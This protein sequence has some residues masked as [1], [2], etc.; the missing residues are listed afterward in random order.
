MRQTITSML[1][2]SYNTKNKESISQVKYTPIKLK[3]IQYYP[4]RD[5]NSS[6]FYTTNTG[7]SFQFRQVFGGTSVLTPFW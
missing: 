2:F 4:V 7:V 6:S 3:K 5:N 1:S